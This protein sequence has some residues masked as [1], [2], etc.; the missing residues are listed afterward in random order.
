MNKTTLQTTDKVFFALRDLYEG[1]GYGLYKMRKFEEYAL[2]LDNKSFLSSTSMITFPSK[3]GKLLA[4]K[5][6]VTLSIVKNTK[7]TNEVKEKLYYRES[8]FRQDKRAGEFNEISQIGLECL[9]ALDD[10]TIAEICILATDSLAL[11]D[12]DYLLNISHMGFVSAILEEVFGNDD[13]L[14]AKCLGFLKTKNRHDFS[15]LAEE[16]NINPRAVLALFDAAGNFET[17]LNSI[18]SLGQSDAARLAFAELSSLC[19]MMKSCNKLPHIRIDFSMTNDA[20]YYNGIIL[21]GYVKGVCRA[22]LSGGRYDKLLHKMGHA[23]GAMGFALYLD[24]L[25]FRYNTK[26]EFDTDIMLLYQE[27]D[28]KAKVLAYAKFLRQKGERVRIEKT[29]PDGVT[30]RFC[31]PFSLDLLDETLNENEDLHKETLDETENNA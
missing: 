21:Q 30:H 15:R 25:A 16:N 14:K 1:A 13:A 20:N 27:N 31:I 22:I 7:A 26:P 2:Y 9:G 17:T 18:A 6:D 19:A 29:L 24:E 4:M 11:I 3:T 8:V 28:N 5:P 23:V 12:E 10:L